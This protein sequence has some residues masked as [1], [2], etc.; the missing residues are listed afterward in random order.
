VKQNWR[1]E[2]IAEIE[3]LKPY[4]VRKHGWDPSVLQD[5]DAIDLFVRL[6]GRRLGSKAYQLRLRYQEDWQT[7]GR[8]EAFVDPDD[9]I[10]EGVEFWPPT[11]IRGINPEYRPPT[12]GPIIPCICLRGVWGYHSLLHANESAEG[13]SLL[14]FLLELQQVVDE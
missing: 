3:S 2:A 14:G 11:G 9:R 13:T 4:W 12:G 6:K 5:D 1:E 8:R 10:R 7:A